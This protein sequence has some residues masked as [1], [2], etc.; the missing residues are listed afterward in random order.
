MYTLILC[1]GI[2]LGGCMQIR[3]LEFPSYEA[4][5]RERK[6]VQADATKFKTLQLT[7]ALCRPGPKDPGTH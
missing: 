4:C 5:D 1:Y 2:F 3:Q 7:Y 6:T